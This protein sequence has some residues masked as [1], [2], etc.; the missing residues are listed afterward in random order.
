VNANV[1]PGQT[2][3][4][5]LDDIFMTVPEIAEMGNFKKS[6]P[7]EDGS[8]TFYKQI[9][10]I[11]SND[12]EICVHVDVIEYL[13]PN[14]FRRKASANDIDVDTGKTHH[15]TKDADGNEFT[16]PNDYAEY[17]YIFTG[18]NKDVLSLELKVQEFQMLLASNLKIGPGDLQDASPDGKPPD[19]EV[20]RQIEELLNAR[21][22]DPI[23]LPLLS[24]AQEAGFTNY[25]RVASAK[26]DEAKKKR[27]NYTRNLSMFYS[28][29]PIVT[30][31][32]IRGNPAIMHKFN[33][34]VLATHTSKPEDWKTRRAELENRILAENTNVGRD[35][36]KRLTIT[37][38]SNDTYAK[39]PVF[40]KVNIF[41]PPGDDEWS[42]KSSVLSDV[43]YVVFK[44]SNVIQNGTFTQ[45]LELYSHNV[46]GPSKLGSKK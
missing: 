1:K 24:K 6:N 23:Y 8:V 46:F 21:P 27:Q 35:P 5:A 25:A 28:G 22:N 44:L 40:V 38:F 39:S 41:G 43:Y 37:G 34:G 3:V 31:M 13:V 33:I 18:R 32:G 36:S 26:Q 16:L 42:N 10:G 29:S 12:S 20:T 45:E 7:S 9:T 14:A 4:Q 15:T 30:T 11:T 19:P 17:D 2:I